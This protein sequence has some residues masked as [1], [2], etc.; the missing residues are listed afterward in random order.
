MIY[1]LIE[2]LLII[3]IGIL[4][5]ELIFDLVEILCFFKS[6][7]KIF[8]NIASFV[9]MQKY[10]STPEIFK[11]L[12]ETSSNL[13]DVKYGGYGCSFCEYKRNGDVE[14]NIFADDLINS[15]LSLRTPRS[16]LAS[17]YFHELGHVID[18]SYNRSSL[19]F[20]RS[21][22]S[23]NIFRYALE[24]DKKNFHAPTMGMK[25]HGSAGSRPIRR[26]I[27]IIRNFSKLTFECPEVE[28]ILDIVSDGNVPVIYGHS[29][30]YY[31][32]CPASRYNE[33]FANLFA[34]YASR[35]YKS[36]RRLVKVYGLR[37]LVDRFITW[38][39]RMSVERGIRVDEEL[40]AVLRK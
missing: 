39:A 25:S 21:T 37:H 18:F 9:C 35:D 2:I 12:L 31:E 3:V 36:L 24:L 32:K 6:I 16:F 8:A 1:I 5:L 20:S 26:L 33:I 40:N 30:S 29:K 10:K 7:E 28:D 15:I 13:I 23:E 14:V 19:D 22:V 17:T 34:L 38:V 11:K 27:Y 4:S